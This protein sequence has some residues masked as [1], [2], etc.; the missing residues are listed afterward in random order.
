MIIFRCNA[1]SKVG[2]GHLTRCT[3]LAEALL[4][5]GEPSM[6]VG[7]SQKFFKKKETQVFHDWIEKKTWESSG[8]DAL[9]LINI[10]KKSSSNMIILDDYRVD[11]EYQYTLKK[12]EFHWLQ[13]DN[14][15]T[16]TILA[17]IV[18]N[19]NPVVSSSSYEDKLENPMTKLLLGLNYAIV[20][21]EFPPKKLK[22]TNLDNK[23]ILITFG[24]GDD[25][26]AILFVLSSLLEQ[27]LKN[28]KFIVVSG[29][30]N[31]NNPN[32]SS[33]IENHASDNVDLMVN[34]DCI[35]ELFASCDFAIM[36][37]GTTVYEVSSIGLPMILIAIADNQIQHSSDWSQK[38]NSV[39]F[40][41]RLEDLKKE[42]LTE[43][44]HQLFSK[45]NSILNK[46]VLVDGFGRIR[47]AQEVINTK[48][49]YEKDI[50][51]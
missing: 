42:Q 1:D 36:A 33:W 41:G 34:P 30:N 14:G 26:G 10:A 19:T 2:F 22:L 21:E 18:L 50:S 8:D 11:Y 47:V 20:R 6:M 48:K 9:K 39:K 45:D 3:A 27:K 38:S 43:A 44:F 49:K 16:T 4:S 35:A 23:K 29:I 5:L 40:L 15:K 46:K 37:G 28:I 31:P 7:P 24:A 25:R 32:I 51:S 17:D 12:H 13:F